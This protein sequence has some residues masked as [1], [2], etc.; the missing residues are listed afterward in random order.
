MQTKDDPGKILQFL[1]DKDSLLWGNLIYAVLLSAI[2]I[3]TEQSYRIFTD[4]LHVNL[5]FGDILEIFLFYLLLSF[6]KRR[7]IRNLIIGFYLSFSLLQMFHFS[8][9]G[10]WIFPIEILLFFQKTTETFATFFSVFYLFYMPLILSVVAIILVVTLLRVPLA[11]K[12]S[13]IAGFLMLLLILSSLVKP[14]MTFSNSA[15]RPDFDRSIMRNSFLTIGYFFGKTLPDNVRGISHAPNYVKT[16]YERAQIEPKANVILIIGESLNVDNLSLFGYP[17]KTTPHLELL[18]EDSQF[19]FKKAYASGVLTDV[20]LPSLINMI[21]YPDGTQ[22]IIRGYTNLFRMAKANGFVTHFISAQTTD[23]LRFFKSYLSPASIDDFFTADMSEQ[24]KDGIYYDSLLMEQLRDIDFD[25]NNFIVLQEAGSHSPYKDRVPTDK[26]FFQENNILDEY[27]NTVRYSD[28]ILSR[29]VEFLKRSCKSPCYLVFTSNHG[30]AVD[31][32]SYGHGSIENS[33]HYIV[34]FF[35]YAMNTKMP[36]TLIDSIKQTPLMGHFDIAKL[37]AYF[38]GYKTQ[39][40]EKPVHSVF[41]D[42]P[43]LN[44]NSGYLQILVDSA[45]II[46]S[47]RID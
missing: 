39:P 3:I 22:Q 6:I 9:F 1:P 2:T 27:D 31:K 44:G 46:H 45:G 7:W 24:G 35:V 20:S 25:K 18:T 34:P 21:E 43:E 23:D 14:A 8:Y 28:M 15:S 32:N 26:K 17:R 19:V 16:P 29:I 13:P 5:H 37:T 36:T 12:H 4:G 41:V 10:A 40:L 42:G 30:Q 47:N 38:L 33:K 11:S